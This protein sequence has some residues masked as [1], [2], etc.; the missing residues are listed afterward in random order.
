[1]AVPELPLFAKIRNEYGERYIRKYA[2]AAP[3]DNWA[4]R[5]VARWCEKSAKLQNCTPFDLAL[6]LLDG[7]FATSNP[8]V[9]GTRHKL[10]CITKNPGEFLD[11]SAALKPVAVAN[12]GAEAVRRQQARQEAVR[13]DRERAARE[14]ATAV[15]Q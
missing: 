12:D 7:L 15:G 3:S 9:I 4:E 14:A 8:R 5:E 1:V 11:L 10:G 13:L 2:V 6:R